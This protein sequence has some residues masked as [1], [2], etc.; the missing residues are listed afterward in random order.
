MTVKFVDRLAGPPGGVRPAGALLGPS[1]AKV[2]GGT[3]ELRWDERRQWDLTFKILP[4]PAHILRSPEWVG[5]ASGTPTLITA[6]WYS[7]PSLFGVLRTP[8]IWNYSVEDR[9]S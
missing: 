3:D 7:L 6:V 4:D 1:S 5:L 2:N 9:R 8:I